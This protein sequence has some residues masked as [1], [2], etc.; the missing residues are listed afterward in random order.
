MFTLVEATLSALLTV[1]FKAILLALMAALCLASLRIRDSNVHHR[2]WTIVLLGMLVLPVL[3]NALPAFLIPAPTWS[4]LSYQS[5][6]E[7]APQELDALVPTSSAVNLA[8]HTNSPTVE[9]TTIPNATQVEQLQP[10][11]RSEFETL[12]TTNQS[13]I[14][15]TA[16]RPSTATTSWTTLLFAGYAFGVI[17]MLGRLCFGIMYTRRVIRRS[18]RIHSLDSRKTIVM[19]SDD[20]CVPLTV[21]VIRPRILLPADW[22]SWEPGLLKSV[23]RHEKIHIDRRD[24]LVTLLAEINRCLYW[25]HPLAWILR[26]RLARLA[27]VACDDWVISE[28]DNRAEYAGHLL[29]IACRLSSVRTRVTLLGASMAGTSQVEARISAILDANRPLAQRITAKKW[30]VLAALVLPL[31]LLTACVHAVEK[32]EAT[33]IDQA[34]PTEQ[35]IPADDG[36]NA[37]AVPSRLHEGVWA[38]YQ[39]ET[40]IDDKTTQRFLT[41]V[42]L[43]QKTEQGQLCRWLEV[44]KEDEDPQNTLVTRLLIP[45]EHI[46]PG[47]NALE[48]ALVVLQRTGDRP[49][50]NLTD[51]DRS[52]V[53]SDLSLVMPIRHEDSQS[54]DPEAIELKGRMISLSGWSNHRTESDRNAQGLSQ[55]VTNRWWVLESDPLFGVLRAEET[56]K[57]IDDVDSNVSHTTAVII[58]GG[59]G[60]RSRFTGALV[61]P[62]ALTP[63]W[64]WALSPREYDFST[65]A[66]AGMVIRPEK[67]DDLLE[68]TIAYPW[69]TPDGGRYVKYRPVAFDADRKRY[70][71]GHR[72]IS[73]SGD[74]GLGVFTLSNEETELDRIVDIGIERLPPDGLK[75]VAETVAKSARDAGLEPLPFPTIGQPFPFSVTTTNNET[76]RSEDYLGKVVLIDCWATW[77]GPCMAKMPKLKSLYEKWHSHGFEIVGVNSDKSVEIMQ[78]TVESMD[79]PWP[80]TMVPKDP[81]LSDLWSQASGIT[82]LPRL[83]LLD[84]NGNLWADCSPADL[85]QL[86]EQLMSEN[87]SDHPIE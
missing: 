12:A 78:M 39:V 83:L 61:G 35:A 26:T 28:T 79:L 62:F 59:M 6:F 84:R 51:T 11:H 49:P 56:I 81:D 46:R 60:A 24:L 20:V 32:E 7:T 9:S 21:G 67:Q 86:I 18:R 65:M 75:I 40:L 43:E 17:A 27:E 66:T 30:S 22:S 2:V 31:V 52:E 68:L 14:A 77:C 57:Q 1:S 41:I 13:Q 33:E 73:A 44:I 87:Q 58:D 16:L 4:Q 54:H 80:Q 29:E 23:L 53:Q 69:K 70:E 36:D 48:R 74:L 10:Q 64:E 42:I 8:S 38:K 34:S 5:L 71:F 45:E 37:D 85:E 19:Q 47:V 55:N 25:F 72:G 82:S 3:G 63:G 76:L 15:S 50:V